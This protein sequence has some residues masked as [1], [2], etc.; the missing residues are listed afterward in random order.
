MTELDQILCADITETNICA[1]KIMVFSFKH[2]VWLWSLN[3]QKGQMK[4]KNQC[5]WIVV[6][7]KLV[8]NMLDCRKKYSSNTRWSK[9]NCSLETF[10]NE[11]KVRFWTYNTD[12]N[13]WRPWCLEKLKLKAYLFCCFHLLITQT[14]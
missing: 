5:L 7:E 9:T 6:R 4:K 1:I 8:A 13:H 3:Y 14:I 10:N 11:D 12:K 2:F